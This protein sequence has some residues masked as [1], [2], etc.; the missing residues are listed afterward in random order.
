MSVAYPVKQIQNGTIQIK[1]GKAIVT[2]PSSEGC[3]AM[4]SP[5]DNVD[6][7]VDGKIIKT[8]T[9]VTADNK[10]KIV[11]KEIPGEHIININADKKKM[12]V[13][14]GVE[15][16]SGKKYLVKDFGPCGE[17][18]E[19]ECQEI[20]QPPEPLSL[21]EVYKAL[22][23]RGIVYGIDKAAIIKAV[24]D[25][26][27]EAVI[28]A[29]GIEAQKG[30]DARIE[31]CF[32]D[33]E[34]KEKSEDEL[35]V[36]HFDY[37]TIAS[38]EAGMVVARKI[39]AKPGTP[40]MDVTGRKLEPPGTRDVQLKAGSGAELAAGGWEAVA[41]VNGRPQLRGCTV[42]VTPV[43]KVKGDVDKKT[44]NVNFA[45]DVVVE[46]NVL[47]AMKVRA[48]GNIRILGFVTHCQIEA[49]GD[50]F[51]GRNAISSSVK[52]GGARVHLFP[53]RDNLRSV[54]ASFEELSKILEQCFADRRIL[55]RPE[56]KKYG[57][58]A[59]LKILLDTRFPSLSGEMQ[60][61]DELLAVLVSGP[62]TIFDDGLSLVTAQ[63][64]QRF[65]GT[66]PLEFGTIEEILEA[67]E[68][69][70][71]CCRDSLESIQ[72]SLQ[73]KSTITLGYVQHSTL[74]ATGDVIILGKGCYNTNIVCG[75][76]V[77]A[78]EKKSFF[79]GGQIKAEGNVDI[80]EL[81]SLG[82][83]ITKVEVPSN[84]IITAAVSHQGVT[85]KQGAVVKIVGAK[86]GDL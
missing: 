54:L 13:H 42:T 76:S 16:T 8:K 60:Q 82:G 67:V 63:L 80:Y 17:I 33:G 75:G 48:G 64:K 56:V 37:G 15:A 65:S 20:I 21:E 26:T 39:A 49:G 77:T 22:N 34:Y 38:V 85:I 19:I 29:S 35:W 28:V 86:A 11:G 40:G 4:L 7:Y 73:D 14:L 70:V 2:D 12:T 36:D 41:K 44:G 45:G 59:V 55:D 66:G 78:K 1:N 30:Q 27:G 51:I 43:Y 9:E 61:L 58:G 23:K 3:F 79:R 10:I 32:H 81:G 46:G 52:A 18:T 68:N 47:D 24:N 25:S 31:A 84:K 72:W 53:I 83:A 69:F 5:S 50:I 57:P 71:A 74:E 6:I 62:G